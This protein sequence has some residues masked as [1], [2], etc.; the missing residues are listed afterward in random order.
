MTLLL[1]I[2]PKSD[3]KSF[4]K[5]ARAG[6]ASGGTVIMSRYPAANT[7][8]QL[9]GFGDNAGEVILI[10]TSEERRAAIRNSIFEE[11]KRR[12]HPFGCFFSLDVSNFIKNNE[13]MDEGI[14]EGQNTK[15]ELI[16]AIVNR[17]Y[18]DDVMAAARKAGATGGT[19]VLA[20][21]TAKETDEKFFGME[22]VPEKDMV[23]IL[24]EKE[25][26]SAILKA[27]E[28]LPFLKTA[29]SGIVF[30]MPASDVAIFGGEKK[31]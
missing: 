27:L 4:V 23:L 20:R 24:S 8:L 30:S 28:E 26:A 7:V 25:E 13:W 21:G 29:G 3:G 5:A 6:G 1:A 2:V 18:A 14:M 22:I 19:V 10:L 16:T 9:L 17:G 12:K 11:M 15:H 31:V